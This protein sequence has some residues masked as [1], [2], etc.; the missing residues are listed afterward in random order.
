MEGTLTVVLVWVLLVAQF[1]VSKK[2]DSIYKTVSAASIAAKVRTNPHAHTHIE[3]AMPPTSGS[4]P[5]HRAAAA[6]CVSSAV[7]GPQ[8][9]RD[10]VLAR[11]VWEEGFTAAPDKNFGSGYP[12]DPRAAEVG[13]ARPLHP[14]TARQEARLLMSGG[15]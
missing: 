6:V 12:S 7:V 8:V 1:T 15:G 11:W 5:M 9:T 3:G 10:R 13:Q 14:H 2:A 4:G